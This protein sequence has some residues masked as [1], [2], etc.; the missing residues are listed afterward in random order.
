MPQRQEHGHI[1][2]LRL[3]QDPS[4]LPIEVCWLV[5]LIANLQEESSD[6]LVQLFNEELMALI[7]T[8]RKARLID[9]RS[10][11]VQSG[12]L[13]YTPGSKGRPGIYSVCC[14]PD[15]VSK[16]VPK[17]EKRYAQRTLNQNKVAQ[18]VPK[19]PDSVSKSVPQISD[20]ETHPPNPKSITEK[21]NRGGRLFDMD[22]AELKGGEGGVSLGAP[23][24]I[25][26]WGGAP[27][28]Q[29]HSDAPQDP[30]T[31]DAIR[32]VFA[33]YRTHH[34]RAHP[35]PRAESREWRAIA[36]RL[37]EG[38][39]VTDLF[40]AIDGCHKC[41]FN[42]GENDRQTRYLSL[43]LIV[44]TSDHVLKFIEANRET[45]KPVLSEK[46]QRAGRALESYLESR[47]GETGL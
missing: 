43:G 35:K 18:I 5:M 37:K 4:S 44:R 2:A 34:P 45:N 33:H 22:D 13:N 38:Y 20:P 24:D 12:W 7:R 40:E 19:I 41:P 1:T 9:I 36:A 11:A 23:L 46:S 21:A 16:N 10:R 15:S 8:N 47:F 17:I 26:L 3:A 28:A 25:Q 30:K 31:A 14:Q 32:A 42:L 29:P 39:T 6:G 27:A